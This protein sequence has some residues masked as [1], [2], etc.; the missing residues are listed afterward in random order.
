MT[1]GVESIFLRL[2]NC[3]LRCG[4]DGNGWLCDTW[5]TWDQTKPEFWKETV[6]APVHEVADRIIDVW[7]ERFGDTVRTPNLV[8]SG[9]EPLMQQPK[10]VELLSHLPSWTF[11]IKTNGTY[12]PVDELQQ[13]QINCSPKLASSGNSLR[14]RFRP[15]VL[16]KIAT[17]PKHW[18]KFVITDSNFDEDVSEVAS[19]VDTVGIDPT[20]VLM[21]CEGNDVA[22][23]TEHFPRV[24]SAAELLGFTAVQRMHVFW[25][26]N[27]RAS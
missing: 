17:F 4:A 19:M 25:F 7:Q 23:L 8:I 20:R 3:N 24:V 26:G 1:A 22:S 12:A 16:Q 2:Q 18:F 11:E 15:E 6:N 27:K 21:M 13:C 5:Y 10:I 9:G 14:A